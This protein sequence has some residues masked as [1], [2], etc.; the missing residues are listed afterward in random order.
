M[1]TALV[2]SSRIVIVFARFNAYAARIGGLVNVYDRAVGGG[3]NIADGG[4]FSVA[5]KRSRARGE[6]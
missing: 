4:K 1:I 2:D 6:T 5:G 3:E